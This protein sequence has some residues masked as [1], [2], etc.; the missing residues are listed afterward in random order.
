[1]F[2]YNKKRLYIAF[3]HRQSTANNPVKYHTALLVT[4]KNPDPS[5]NEEDSYMYHVAN[6]I[7]ALT[8]KPTWVFEGKRTPSRVLYLAG[9]MLI[10][11]L[12][13]SVAVEKL[14]AILRK[15]PKHTLVEDNPTWR[16]RH[17]IWDA[18]SVSR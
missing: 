12:P 1:M 8:K 4:P 17:W 10:G 18:L 7:D 16:C 13:E 5:S 11:K 9:L 15:V 2:G 6:R 14:E 3:L